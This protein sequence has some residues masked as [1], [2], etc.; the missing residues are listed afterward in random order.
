MRTTVFSTP[1]ITPLLRLI[2]IALLKIIGWKAVGKELDHPRFVLIGAPHTSNWDFPLMLLV[3]LK[4]RLK[5]FWMGKHTLFPFPLGWFMKWLGGIPIDRNKSHNVV[6]DTVRQYNENE[7]L[8]VLVPPEGTRK[9][10]AKWKTGFYHIAQNAKVPIL[11]G[12]VDAGKKEAGIA[13][14]YYPSGNLEQDMEEILAF[15]ANKKG[16]RAENS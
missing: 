10:V 9:K 6:T 5:V 8:V 14:Y 16:L 7:D 12:Y 2:A 13:D 11:M 1:L 15:Y 3:V 4:L